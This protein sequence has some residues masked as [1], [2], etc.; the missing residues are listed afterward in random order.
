MISNRVAGA[1]L[2]LAAVTFWLS[3]LLM[4]GVGVIDAHVIL[5][6]V[7]RERAS[8]SASVLVQLVSAALFAPALIGMAMLARARRSRLLEAGAVILLVGAMGSAADAIIH[9]VAYE[10][11]DPN[12]PRGAML[13]VMDRLQ[14]GLPA[15]LGFMVAAFF[16]GA[17][18]LAAGA[19][20][21]RLVGWV[22]LFLVLGG[23]ALL[24][25]AGAFAQG[26]DPQRTLGLAGLGLLSLGLC[27]V[28]V[29]L[30]REAG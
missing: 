13:P 12:A 15:Y 14:L 11:T 19:A 3:W 20:R 22:C 24:P 16:L 25:I 28:G 1:S 27:W 26:S 5:E 30:A 9:L 17:I 8:V 23:C 2:V 29:A 6:R 7:A 21:A 10:M 4:P 18:A